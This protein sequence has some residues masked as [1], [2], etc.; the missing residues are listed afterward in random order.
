[1][2]SLANFPVKKYFQPGATKKILTSKNTNS[3]ELSGWSIGNVTQNSDL[4]VDL[5]VTKWV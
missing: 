4:L 2:E 5:F 3:R 1:M